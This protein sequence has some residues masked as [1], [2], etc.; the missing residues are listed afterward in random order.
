MCALRVWPALCTSWLT[1]AVDKTGLERLNSRGTRSLISL[2]DRHACV[3]HRLQGALLW[4]GR[5]APLPPPC[6]A[7]S[8]HTVFEMQVMPQ[9]MHA[10][11]E[12][13]A[14]MAD[15]GQCGN[16]P[17]VP[18]CW[19]WTTIAVFTCPECSL[20]AGHGSFVEHPVLV[21]QE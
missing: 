6:A 9:L 10:L 5:T 12:A 11:S 15:A 7:C 3:L 17:C 20:A 2:N 1:Q 13:E 21:A 18:D 19:D 16:Q 14:M 8:G 4:P